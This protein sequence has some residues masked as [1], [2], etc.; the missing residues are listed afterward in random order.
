MTSARQRATD[1]D[2]GLL[3]D[4]DL[5]RWW[6]FYARR[7]CLVEEEVEEAGEPESARAFYAVHVEAAAR[8]EA[9]RERARARGV[10]RDADHFPRAFLDDLRRRVALDELLEHEWGARLGARTPGGQRRGPC[11]LCRTSPR[12]V[13]LV[14]YLADP[15]D[16]WFRCYSC[17][18]TGDAF[19]A[20][21]L[22][23]DLDFPDAVR[24]LAANGGIPCPEGTRGARPAAG[25][26]GHGHRPRRADVVWLSA[27]RGG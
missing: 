6:R 2:Y 11:P 25:E 18:V 26:R 12:S 7:L 1:L 22:A 20:I 9:S 19:Q 24:R 17:W 14:A 23:Y 5:R 3:A 27:K 15:D 4:Q 10:P 16:Q 21:A 8:E 13:C